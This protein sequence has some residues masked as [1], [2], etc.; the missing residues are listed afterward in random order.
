[1]ALHN[2]VQAGE[3]FEAIFQVAAYAG[4]KAAWDALDKLAEVLKDGRSLTE[5][6]EISIDHCI[7]E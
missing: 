5:D 4:L 1:M 2:G 7:I 6:K 3:I